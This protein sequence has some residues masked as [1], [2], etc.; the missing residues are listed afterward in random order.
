VTSADEFHTDRSPETRLLQPHQ[1]R[2]RAT[3]RCAPELLNRRVHRPMPLGTGVHIQ[4]GGHGMILTASHVLDSEYVQKYGLFAGHSALGFIDLGDFS[5]VR[6]ASDGD[7]LTDDDVDVAAVLLTPA[8]TEQL[9]H[10][11]IFKPW[12]LISADNLHRHSDRS[13]YLI[14]GFAVD[15]TEVLEGGRHIKPASLSGFLPLQSDAND[16]WPARFPDSKLDFQYSPQTVTILDGTR[17]TLNLPEPHGLS[18]CGV[19]QVFPADESSS[20]VELP[21]NLVAIVH[22]FNR[23]LVTLR[24]TRL[25]TL[26]EVL[27]NQLLE[28]Q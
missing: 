17:R 24:A 23:A 22:R 27:R 14:H 18:G 4:S 12:S 28:S 7:R 6:T 16:A 8:I 3:V 13:T 2:N 25:E 11:D 9:R 20:N 21:M 15:L 19:W 10:N 1:R 26:F 5:F